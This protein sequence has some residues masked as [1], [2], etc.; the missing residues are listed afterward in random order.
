MNNEKYLKALDRLKH[1]AIQEDALPTIPKEI[2]NY[3]ERQKQGSTLRSAIIDATEFHNVDDDKA[4]WIFYQSDVFALAWL[5][6]SWKVKET[7]EIVK[8][9]EEK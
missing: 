5:L 3:I 4:D 7:G 8:L 1:W 6:G 2:G 9:E